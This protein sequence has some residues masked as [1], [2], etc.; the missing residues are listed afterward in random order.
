MPPHPSPDRPAPRL[1]A[2]PR[3]GYDTG[4][5][6]P[7]AHLAA[8]RSGVAPRRSA[9]PPSPQATDP[10]RMRSDVP[11]THRIPAFAPVRVRGGVPS[12]H[13]AARHGRRAAL[14][15]AAGVVVAL[16]TS[17]WTQHPAGERAGASTPARDPVSAPRQKPAG[18]PLVHAPVRIADP[19]V[20]RFLEPGDRVDVVAAPAAPADAAGPAQRLVAAGA[21]VVHVPVPTDDAVEAGALVILSA[22]RSTA[23]R[24]AGASVSSRLTVVMGR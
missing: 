17:P 6:I 19:A 18:A 22:P 16:V 10:V 9:A 4:A 2:A 14:V 15:C 20:A 21:R 1:P 24:L 7:D 23:V 3:Y 13:R 8:G 12:W 11:P 5:T